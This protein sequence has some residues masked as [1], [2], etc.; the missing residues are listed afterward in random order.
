MKVKLRCSESTGP[1]DYV[2]VN[3]N[4]YSPVQIF[5]ITRADSKGNG[6]DANEYL[7][8]NYNAEYN[9]LDFYFVFQTHKNGDM[10]VQSREKHITKINQTEVFNFEYKDNDVINR[11]SNVFSINCNS[12]RSS[13]AISFYVYDDST[14]SDPSESY[15]YAEFKLILDKPNIIKIKKTNWKFANIYIKVNNNWKLCTLWKKI[16]G[17][18]KK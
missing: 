16:N 8:F 5:G 15:S 12:N 17:V 6:Y 10:I 11:T 18:W 14:L 1:A 2:R 13:N 3:K 4:Y 7:Y 9:R